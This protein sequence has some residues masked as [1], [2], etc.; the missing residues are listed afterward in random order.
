MFTTAHVKGNRRYI[1]SQRVYEV[2]RTALY[3]AVAIS[4]FVAGW[5]QTGERTNLLTV[6]AI[7]GCLPAS[8][9][10]VGAIM[11]F[12]YSGCDE[13]TAEEIA[14][15]A[16]DLT[17]LFDCVFTS[18]KKTHQIAHLAVRG[19]TICGY[20]SDSKFSDKDFGEHLKHHLSLDGHKN[21]SVKVFT[22]I[23]KYQERLE[24]MQQLEEDSATSL[25]ILSTLRS[26]M[27]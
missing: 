9:S 16:G 2:L 27:L 14:T 7:L 25:A 24:Q 11:Y 22:D 4:L 18:A 23:K 15:H 21:V 20:T 5:V 17:C 19:G 13:Q 3:F 26:I 12:R 6:V 1:K 8:K 10:L